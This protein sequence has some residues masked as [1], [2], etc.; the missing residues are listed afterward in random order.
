MHT[1]AAVGKKDSGLRRFLRRVLRLLVVVVIGAYIALAIFAG[2]LANGVIFQPHASSYS[3]AKDFVKLT[4]RDGAQISAVYLKN[5]AARYTIL[6][7]HGNAEDMGDLWPF[8][9]TLRNFGFSVMAYD[10]QGYGTSGGKPTEQYAY[11][12]ADAVYDYLTRA[13]NTRRLG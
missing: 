12:D 1:G 4:S 2:F 6:F 11:D 9:Y 7:S 5:D 13:L 8:L 3:D 10:Y